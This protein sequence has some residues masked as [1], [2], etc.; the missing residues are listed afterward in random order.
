MRYFLGAGLAYSVTWCYDDLHPAMEGN[1]GVVQLANN[2]PTNSF[3]KTTP[4][5]GISK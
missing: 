2:H 4:I 3:I 1:D 5:L